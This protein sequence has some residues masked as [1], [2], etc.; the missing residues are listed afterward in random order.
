MDSAGPIGGSPKS[1][2]PVRRRASA[3]R[4][5]FSKGH[6]RWLTVSLKVFLLDRVEFKINCFSFFA[7]LFV[8][9][10]QSDYF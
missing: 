8:V 1:S 4:A 9:L 7:F 6:S 5:W 2:R 3:H 10:S